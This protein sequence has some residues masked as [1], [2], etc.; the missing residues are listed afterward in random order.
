[1]STEHRITAVTRI[2]EKDIAAVRDHNPIESV[3]SEYT[4]LDPTDTGELAGACPLE[5]N[6]APTLVV[7]PRRGTFRCS[8]CGEGG[9]VIAFVMKAGQL[10]F[11]EAVRRLAERAGI[12]VTRDAAT[13]P[14][15]AA[16]DLFDVPFA[17][18]TPAMVRESYHLLW[19]LLA[20]YDRVVAEHSDLNRSINEPATGGVTTTEATGLA[21]T[22]IGKPPRDH[23]DVTYAESFIQR[24]EDEM[25]RLYPKPK[26]TLADAVISAEYQWAGCVTTAEDFHAMSDTEKQEHVTALVSELQQQGDT[27]DHLH[28]LLEAVLPQ[29]YTHITVEDAARRGRARLA[30]VQGGQS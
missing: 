29:L 3:V 13:D 25:T 4:I 26:P 23:E 19:P 7:H 28:E 16:T 8:G 11:N 10:G 21:L 1:M 18:R 15:P 12:A 17:D 24:L 14:A 27:A 2:R 6:Y 9:D 22:A 30:A 5:Q 20:A